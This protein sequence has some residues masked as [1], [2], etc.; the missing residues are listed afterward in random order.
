MHFLFL[1]HLFCLPVSRFIN[2]VEG[3]RGSRFE[4]INVLAV[5]RCWTSHHAVR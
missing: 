4:R 5:C 3:L 1:L 2:T